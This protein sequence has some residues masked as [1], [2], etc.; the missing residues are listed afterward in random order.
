[1]STARKLFGTDGVRG[2]ANAEPLTAD[3]VLRLARAGAIEIA[4][5][6]GRRLRVV[7]GRDTRLSGDLLESALI[8]GLTSVGAEVHRAGVIP[9]PGVALLARELRADAGIAITA[10]HNPFEDNGLKFFRGDGGKLDDALEARIEARLAAGETTAFPTGNW[11]GRVHRI[12]DAAER[13]VAHA[14]ASLPERFALPGLR[15]A[16][17]CANGA[18]H[19]TTPMALRQLGAD[20]VAFHTEPDGT[21]INRDC[22]STH[23]EEIARR[24]RETGASIGVSHDG[25]ADRLIVC[26]EHAETVDGDELLAIAALD[27]LRRGALREST[28]AVTVMSNFGLDEA[29]ASAG[30]KVVRTAVGDRYVLAEMLAKGLNVGGEQSGHLIFLDHSSTGDGLVAA[31]QI[32]RVMIE[33][34]K[35]L[36]ELKRCLVK[37]P[38]AQRDLRVTAKPALASLAEVTREIA[39]AE[40]AL[41]G[42]G[43]VL[44]RFSGTEPKV[45][46]LVEGRDA[47][48][49]GGF[50]DAIT[51]ALK[52]A[53]G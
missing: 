3:T 6:T 21:N 50:A 2:L 22:G 43:R 36:S 42:R 51:G 10:S 34:G 9:T 38:Q 4:G 37:Y 29:L 25:D 1:M 52:S 47:T 53:I 41:A 26:D 13:Y 28:L 17:D 39:A 18:S 32:L 44:V 8:A 30:G 20:V 11:I 14:C 12:A 35:P 49:I 33:S 31:L 23:P 24:V 5:D 16:V 27:H 48:Q 7:V 45:R 40:R 19:L 46:V 15:I